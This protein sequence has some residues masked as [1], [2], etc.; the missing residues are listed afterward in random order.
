MAN[1]PQRQPQGQ[2]ASFQWDILASVIPRLIAKQMGKASSGDAVFDPRNEDEKRQQNVLQ[3]TLDRLI[4]KL[5]EFGNRLKHGPAVSEKRAAEKLGL[6]TKEFRQYVPFMGVPFRQKDGG[7][8]EIREKHLEAARVPDFIETKL[9][10][11]V[12]KALGQTV[13]K[14]AATGPGAAAAMPSDNVTGMPIRGVENRDSIV[15]RLSQAARESFQP[16]VKPGEAAAVKEGQTVRVV[17]DDQRR[18]E[19]SSDDGMKERIGRSVMR[20]AFV[21]RTVETGRKTAWKAAKITRRQARNAQKGFRNFGKTALGRT[22]PGQAASRLG[23]RLAGGLAGR[24]ANVGRMASGVSVASGAGV[25]AAGAAAGVTAGFAAIAGVAVGLVSA[26][27]G[28]LAAS[29]SLSTRWNEA[30]RELATYNGMIAGAMARLDVG[31]IRRGMERGAQTQESATDL[32]DAVNRMEQSLLPLR[33]D[34][35]IGFNR[36]GEFLAELVTGVGDIYGEIRGDVQQ[37]VK[38]REVLDALNADNPLQEVINLLRKREKEDAPVGPHG[39]EFANALPF[40]QETQLKAGKLINGA[41]SLEIP[42]DASPAIRRRMERINQS[43][44]R[45]GIQMRD[46]INPQWEERGF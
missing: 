15:H 7:E 20:Q 31:R 26:F 22:I 25:T 3:R 27:A 14:A 40:T 38:I 1:E 43:R 24:A 30:N 21:S 35:N 5:D 19:T 41:P 42:E 29:K 11:S 37:L 6:T 36:V 18:G 8:V 17:V 39:K 13:Q 44:E 9:D 4:D 12:S 46:Q 45:R 33:S 32:A 28:L 10:K 16:E 23:Q 2:D 34:I